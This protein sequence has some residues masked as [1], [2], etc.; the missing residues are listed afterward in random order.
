MRWR[1]FT[2]Q[3]PPE[4]VSH[5]VNLF[6]AGSGYISLA[7]HLATADGD[8]AAVRTAAARA[9]V[10]LSTVESRLALSLTWPAASPARPPGVEQTAAAPQAACL[11]AA[12]EYT[13]AMAAAMHADG[14]LAVLQVRLAQALRCLER[15]LHGSEPRGRKRRRRP[16]A[17]PHRP[18]AAGCS[19]RLRVGRRV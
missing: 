7:L 4:D 15:L 2:A 1:A 5:L 11:T 10:Y 12:R 17:A 6:T 3:L 16:P 18:Q 19:L 8:A 13:R 9:H 14:E